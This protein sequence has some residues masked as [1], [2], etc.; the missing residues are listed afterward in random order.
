MIYTAIF[1]CVIGLL[2]AI[3]VFWDNIVWDKIRKEKAKR[4]K[5]SIGVSKIYK[6]GDLI[7]PNDRISFEGFA[8]DYV[9]SINDYGNT[10]QYTIKKDFSFSIDDTR[11]RVNDYNSETQS[12]ALTIEK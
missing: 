3:G 7:H 9:I 1:L 5:D 11:Y 2:F 12:L 8:S 6:P 4:F 10:K